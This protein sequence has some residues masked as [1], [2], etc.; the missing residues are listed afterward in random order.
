[1]IEARKENIL[2]G[3]KPRLD[4]GIQRLELLE[5]CH[6]Q[7]LIFLALKNFLGSGVS[8]ECEEE[9][10]DERMRTTSRLGTDSDQ[11]EAESSS[12]SGINE[13]VIQ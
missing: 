13:K 9:D 7:I 3:M 4:C 1:M 8:W 5:G 10:E 12:S 11:S 2:R 6:K